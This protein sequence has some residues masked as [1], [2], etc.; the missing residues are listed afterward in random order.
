VAQR[1]T[2]DRVALRDACAAMRGIA[3]SHVYH[4]TLS[5]ITSLV[6]AFRRLLDHCK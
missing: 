1:L 4:V 5:L 2:A 6:L 3:Q